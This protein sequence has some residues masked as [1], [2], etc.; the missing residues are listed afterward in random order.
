MDGK[1]MLDS[2]QSSRLH[3]AFKNS[4]CETSSWVSTQTLLLKHHLPLQ[5]FTWCVCTN[6]VLA[7]PIT[8]IFSKFLEF[9][10]GVGCIVRPNGITDR[11]KLFSK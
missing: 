9:D 8:Y 7:S 10:V 2:R 3:H 5:G 1:F 11:E 6:P 4:G